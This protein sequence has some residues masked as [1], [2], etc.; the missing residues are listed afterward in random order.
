MAIRS[1][2]EHGIAVLD[3]PV[4][5]CA[6]SFGAAARPAPAPDATLPRPHPAFFA[7]GRADRSGQAARAGLGG[8]PVHDLAGRLWG[9]AGSFEWN[10]RPGYW[11]ADRQS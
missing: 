11:L 3:R 2:A 9:L 10:Y 5:G 1:G 8:H 4:S 7:G 6:S